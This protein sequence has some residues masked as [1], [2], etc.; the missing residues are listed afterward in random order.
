MDITCGKC[1]EP[2]DNDSLHDAV[3]E[4]LFANYREAAAAFRSEGC[5]ALGFSHNESTMGSFRAMVSDAMMD[6]LGDDMDGASSIMDD[7]EYMGMLD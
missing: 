1:A 4:G 2:T 7:F 3:E 6:L 5:T